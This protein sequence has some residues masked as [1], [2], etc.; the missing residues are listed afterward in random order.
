M[1]WYGCIN[2]EPERSGVT[3]KSRIRTGHTVHI[4]SEETWIQIKV[5]LYNMSDVGS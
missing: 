5:Y 2:R 3:G 4:G 1:A